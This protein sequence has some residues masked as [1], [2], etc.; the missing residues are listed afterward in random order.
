M[1]MDSGYS[2][3]FEIPTVKGNYILEK[4]NDSWHRNLD[5]PALKLRLPLQ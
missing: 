5:R 3:T 1:V 2:H 4:A